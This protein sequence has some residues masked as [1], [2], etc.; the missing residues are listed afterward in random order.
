MTN[1]SNLFVFIPRFTCNSDL[2]INCHG[3]GDD[4]GDA[5]D[6]IVGYCIISP[7][8]PTITVMM[9]IIIKIIK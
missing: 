7:Q 8:T 1:E 6:A 4:S 5:G 9:V 2:V 3:K